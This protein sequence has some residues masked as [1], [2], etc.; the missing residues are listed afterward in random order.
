MR[1]YKVLTQMRCDICGNKTFELR[2]WFE[3]MLCMKCYLTA[4][5]S[6]EKIL[7]TNPTN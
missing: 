3:K 4:R 7:A 1:R 2:H 5:S 6:A